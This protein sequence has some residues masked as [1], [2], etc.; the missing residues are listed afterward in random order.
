MINTAADVR[1]L[2]AFTKYPPVGDRSWGPN[3]AFGLSGLAGPDYFWAAN[4]FLMA[5]AMIETRAAVDNIDEIL[6][7]PGLDGIFVGPA[8]L[9]VAL[10]GGTLLDAFSP[11]VDDALK[12]LQKKTKAAGRYMAAFAPSPE[13]AKKHLE[14]GFALVTHPGEAGF[15]IA[16]AREAIRI[17]RGK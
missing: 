4:N 5:F 10:S 13:Q 17:V 6:V 16:G 8:D 7:V 1:R 11:A 12:L 3:N 14:A 15:I 9:S 2:V